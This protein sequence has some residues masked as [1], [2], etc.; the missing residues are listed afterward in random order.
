MTTI[1][2]SR[3]ESRSLAYGSCKASRPIMLVIIE[4]SSDHGPQKS[5]AGQRPSTALLLSC[6]KPLSRKKHGANQQII[7]DEQ[8]PQKYYVYIYIYKQPL[9]MLEHGF[10][11]TS[12]GIPCVCL[13]PEPSSPYKL[14]IT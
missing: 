14:T 6:V 4:V 1:G 7:Q 8:M 9:I 12:L 3:G 10:R 2:V 5:S 13:D 11:V